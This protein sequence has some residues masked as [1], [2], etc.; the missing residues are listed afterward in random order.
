MDP[1]Q[2]GL[3][4]AAVGPVAVVG[5]WAITFGL[6]RLFWAMDWVDASGRAAVGN[7]PLV[8]LL[9]MVAPVLLLVAPVLTWWFTRR[10]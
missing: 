9:F 1:T 5:A 3:L 6:S 8:F 7:V 2:R 4:I 10:R